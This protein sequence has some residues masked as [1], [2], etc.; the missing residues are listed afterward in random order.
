MVKTS[1]ARQLRFGNSPAERT[2]TELDCKPWS[3]WVIVT[4]LIKSC[5][6]CTQYLRVKIF[7]QAW[8]IREVDWTRALEAD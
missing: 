2:T 5:I 6:G 7:L 4:Q 8:L 1:H 3:Q